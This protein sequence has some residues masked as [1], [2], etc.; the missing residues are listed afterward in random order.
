MSVS[1]WGDGDGEARAAGEEGNGRWEAHGVLAK[2]SW[3]ARTEP[4]D[5]RPH[6]EDWVGVHASTAPDDA[7]AQGPLFVVADGMGGHAAGEV[8]SRVAVEAMLASWTAGTPPPA[9]QALRGA[10]RDANVAVYDAALEQGRRGM[11]TTMVALTLAGTEALVASIGD[12]R[13]YL[14]RDGEVTQL[15]V[16]HSKVGEMVRMRLLTNEQAAQHP[17]RSVLTRCLGQ[18]VAAKVDLARFDTRRDDSFVLCSDGL[19]DVVGKA[20][21]AEVVGGIGSDKWPTPRDAVDELMARALGRDAPDN[22]TCAIVRVTS[23]RPIPAAAG[24]RPFLFRRGR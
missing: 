23:N 24:R 5:V 7:W 14:V 13:A 22:V 1:D 6:N 15:T 19:W 21:L 8:A 3:A 17:M 11:G 4:G 18:D 20:D 10:A 9:Q 16:D 2:L 12:S